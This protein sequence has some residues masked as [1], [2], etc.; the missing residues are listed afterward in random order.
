MGRTTRSLLGPLLG[1]GGAFTGIAAARQ[2]ISTIAGFERSMAQL[3]GVATASAGS[4]A[5]AQAQMVELEDAARNLGATTEFSASQAAE[6]LLF[7][8]RAGF[9]VQESLQAI[10]P[11]INAALAGQVDFAQ[12]A[13][14]VSNVIKQFELN[15]S[16]ATKVV[17]D[18]VI[19]SNRSNTSF[20]QL[21]DALVVAGPIAQQ[22]GISLEET[23]SAIG[24]LGDAGIQTSQAGT[25]LRQIMLNLIDPSDE[26]RKTIE[27]L[28]LSFEQIDPRRVGLDGAFQALAAAGLDAAAATQVF[29]ARNVAAAGVLKNSVDRMRE[30]E[31]ATGR[32]QGEA[33]KASDLVANTLSGSFKSFRSSLEELMLVLG[34]SGLDSA[35]KEIVD[36][37]TDVVRALAGMEGGAE[38]FADGA[39]TAASAAKVLAVALGTAGLAGSLSLAAGAVR[40]LGAAM[41]ANP[42]AAALTVGF[43]AATAATE[44]LTSKLRDL[45]KEQELVNQTAA[46][47]AKFNPQLEAE[48]LSPIQ[49][50]PD[51]FIVQD[52]REA[53]EIFQEMGESFDQAFLEVAQGGL[54]FQREQIESEIA[55]LRSVEA[56]IFANRAA[57][58]DDPASQ[59][60]RAQ[61]DALLATARNEQERLSL[62][63]RNEAREERAKLLLEGF[64][65]DKELAEQLRRQAEEEA[66]RE[67]EHAAE[68]RRVAN[69]QAGDQLAGEFLRPFQEEARILRETGDARQR[70]VALIELENLA[71][72]SGIKLEEVLAGKRLDR[73]L[74]EQQSLENEILSRRELE[75]TFG[76]VGATIGEA[77]GRGILDAIEGGD[78]EEIGQSIL[79]Q[80]A[81]GAAEN[82][83]VKPL[84]GLGNELFGALGSAIGTALG[85]RVGSTQATGATGTQAANNQLNQ[86]GLPTYAPARFA[87]PSVFEPRVPLPFS[88]APTFPDGSRVA[89]GASSPTG[90]GN[91]PIIINVQSTDQAVRTARQMNEQRKREIM[92]RRR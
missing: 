7:L 82:F 16:S 84:A 13:D 53:A 38:G 24:V 90:R 64:L 17:D 41:R 79:R 66:A 33:Q 89:P 67:R 85:G 27:A 75:L 35:L 61:A 9:T 4:L 74:D 57:L 34:E 76:D 22:L 1:L 77:L 5:E 12:A 58:G 51:N 54:K 55:R 49:R 3:Q 80:I 20:A 70:V 65:R 88:G 50:V 86:L 21:A 44:L 18:L 10:Q 73:V 26:A 60:A 45:R 15:A 32:F 63:A 56:K 42:I 36:F 39:E 59:Q 6:G 68:V 31:E 47:F 43:A 30:L 72:E 2:G 19:V 48:V 78:L 37:S 52:A 83:V 91:A 28:G 92:G 8:S 29:E 25:N 69:V 62:L 81:Q 11:T 46:E 87:A 23:A 71:R 40:G 14:I